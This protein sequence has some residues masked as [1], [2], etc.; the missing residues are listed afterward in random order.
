MQLTRC[1]PDA[2][3]PALCCLSPPSLRSSLCPF[4]EKYL[5]IESASFP[6][7][8][9]LNAFKETAQWKKVRLRARLAMR[10]SPKPLG[11]DYICT[12]I[13]KNSYESVQA[14]RK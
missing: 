13:A 8:Q 5:W 14:Y 10:S 4:A 12:G 2:C 7:K 1:R 9:H 11:I 3:S 6:S